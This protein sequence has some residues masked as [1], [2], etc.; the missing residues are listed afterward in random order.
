MSI[1]ELQK[2]IDYE[3]EQET[4]YKKRGKR[5]GNSY[6]RKI[7][8]KKRLNKL[9]KKMNENFYISTGVYFDEKK[10]RL[11]RCWNSRNAKT[12]AHLKKSAN[13]KV[14]HSDEVGCKGNYKKLYDVQYGLC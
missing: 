2:Y 6:K 1:T 10:G 12:P 8:E 9:H 5:N 3:A 4:E 14:R 11:V 13:R 7:E